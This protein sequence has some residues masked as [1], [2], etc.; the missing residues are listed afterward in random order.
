VTTTFQDLDFVEIAGR[1]E[2]KALAGAIAADAHQ[3]VAEA[4]T[5]TI[6]WLEE[7]GRELNQLQK[8]K[9]LECVLRCGDGFERQTLETLMRQF[10]P[11]ERSDDAS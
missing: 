9:L 5:L 2:P 7:E 6:D 10:S 8:T 4:V 11:M 3:R 1:V